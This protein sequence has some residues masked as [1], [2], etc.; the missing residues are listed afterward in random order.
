MSDLEF[1]TDPFE[2]SGVAA[3]E[4]GISPRRIKRCFCLLVVF[5]RKFKEGAV[6]NIVIMLTLWN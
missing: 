2:R 6:L 5:T 1:I 4:R 3:D